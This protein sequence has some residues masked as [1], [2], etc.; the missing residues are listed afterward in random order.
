MS[1]TRGLLAALAVCALLGGSAGC[2]AEDGHGQSNGNNRN[3][4]DSSPVGKVLEHTDEKGRHYR[5]VDRKNAPEVG[6]QI[7]PDT[8]S[9]DG[10][11]GAEDTW[12]VRLILRRFRLSPTGARPVAVAGQGLVR[13]YLDGRL[14]ARL[15]TT[16]YRLTADLA[17][18][19][20]HLTARLYAD[21]GTLWAVDG[22]PVERTAD[23]TA[24]GAG[25]EPPSSQSASPTASGAHGTTA[26]E[27]G[28]NVTA[29]GAHPPV[30]VRGRRS[31]VRTDGGGL[32]APVGKA[33]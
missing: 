18:G 23:I 24:S 6:I 9:T 4:G 10:A 25:T 16:E 21:D 27:G 15:H 31:A 1:W 28:R 12:D 13:L 14:L 33:C 20:H 26:A 29:R 8:G 11:D 19:T 7:E 3:G 5:E 17:R 2:G 30:P 32:P 22:E